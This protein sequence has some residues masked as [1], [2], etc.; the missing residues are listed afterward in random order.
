[1]ERFAALDI[2][3]CPSCGAVARPNILMF[4]DWGLDS[5]RSDAQSAQV[6]AFVQRVQFSGQKLVI[7]ALTMLFYFSVYFSSRKSKLDIVC[8]GFIRYT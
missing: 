4:G 3:L 8:I 6:D 7:I 5:S 1:M 2:P